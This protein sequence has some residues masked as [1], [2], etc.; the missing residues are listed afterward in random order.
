MPQTEPQSTN[1]ILMVEPALFHANPQTRPTNSYQHDDDTDPRAIHEK[2]LGEFRAYRDL[3]VEHGVCVTTLKG[4]AEC[5]DDIFPNWL[6]THRGPGDGERGRLILYPM[7]APN[8]QTERRSDLIELLAP[9]YGE[10]I[11]LSG[12]EKDGKALEATSTL[13]LDRVNRIAW[14]NGSTR[15]DGAVAADWAARTGYRLER[16][17]SEHRGKPVYHADVM[18]WIGTSLAGLCSA[19]LKSPQV[20]ASLREYREVIEFDNDQM[21]RFCGNALEVVGAGGE[22]MLVISKGATAALTDQQRSVIDRHY[23]TLITPDLATIEYYGG[24]SARCMLTEL[25]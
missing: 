7:L 24:G 21:A 20:A 14:S 2:A 1:H 4:R 6:S 12:W 16:F 23:K 25:F 13:V 19:C 10:T 3:L 11:D 9:A 15:S 8:R 5:P 18:M 17:E 22:R